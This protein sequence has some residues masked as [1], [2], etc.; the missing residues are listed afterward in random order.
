MNGSFNKNG[1]IFFRYPVI[2]LKEIGIEA[3]LDIKRMLKLLKAK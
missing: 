3:I 2:T 1:F